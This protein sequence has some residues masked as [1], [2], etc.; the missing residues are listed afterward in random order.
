MKYK[1]IHSF[2]SLNE[3]R[4]Y[5][6]GGAFESNIRLFNIYPSKGTLWVVYIKENYFDSYGCVC[7]TKM[8][9][10]VIKRMDIVY[11]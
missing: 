10:F 5:L 11:V 1:K 9:R 4:I 3:R 8:S 7:A 2:L 6:R